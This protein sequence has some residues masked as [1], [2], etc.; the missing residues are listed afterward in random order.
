MAVVSTVPSNWPPLSWPGASHRPDAMPVVPPPG[1]RR[2]G[3]PSP[4][5]SWSAEAVAGGFPVMMQVAGWPSLTPPVTAVTVRT[6][7]IRVGVTVIFW[8]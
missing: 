1:M 7:V 3:T 5:R 8:S 2:S 4:V 6:L